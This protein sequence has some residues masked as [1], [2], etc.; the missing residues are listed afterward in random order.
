VVTDWLVGDTVSQVAFSEAVSVALVVGTLVKVSVFF[1]GH[2][3]GGVVVPC[4]AQNVSEVGLT[5]WDA[6]PSET[7]PRQMHTVIPRTCQ[8]KEV[9]E[10]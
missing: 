7:S 2:V 10:A 9:A 1:A 6:K 4:T 8:I 3:G 5:A